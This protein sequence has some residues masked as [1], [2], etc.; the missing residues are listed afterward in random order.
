MQILDNVVG[1]VFATGFRPFP[2][3][4]FLPPEVLSSLEY[5]EDDSY[6]TIVLDDKGVSHTN[7]P[8]LGFVGFYRGAFWGVAEMQARSLAEKWMR[9]EQQPFESRSQP[10]SPSMS[11]ATFNTGINTNTSNSQGNE[12]VRQKYY[13]L[14]KADPKLERAQFPMGDYV[15][16]MESFARELGIKRIDVTPEK[17]EERTGPVA[18]ARYQTLPVGSVKNNNNSQIRQLAQR[19]AELTLQTLRA[20]LSPE[21]TSESRQYATSK[22]IFQAF[23]GH[24]AFKRRIMTTVID[25][26]DSS[27]S[28]NNEFPRD[29]HIS[30]TA[31]FHPRYPTAT[32][33]D[34]EYL[35][36]ETIQQQRSPSPAQTVRSETSGNGTY[37]SNNASF[38]APKSVFRF[39][40]VG[41]PGVDGVA[42]HI[43]VWT[44]S[45]INTDSKSNKN[46]D[47]DYAKSNFSHHLHVCWRTSESTA[48]RDNWEIEAVGRSQPPNQGRPA[49]ALASVDDGTTVNYS[50]IYT[51]TFQGVYIVSWKVKVVLALDEKEA[52]TRKGNQSA[53]L[54]RLV[55]VEETVYRRGTEHK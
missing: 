12:P 50:H 22:A 30:G 18:P 54:D 36:M 21:Y 40:E 41:E 49:S 9:Y 24:W 1:V 45:N 23:Q 39:R 42:S 2:S 31:T 7:I 15:G 26:N 20:T 34:S 25:T 32:S 13:E 51:V 29:E 44:L 3:L 5:T 35:Y 8:D 14:R 6:L 4:S 47:G 46:G 19:D 37:S 53:G 38:A 11:L 17:E 43:G 16:L 52:E 55:V 48:Q 33:Y 27:Q 28:P 10:R